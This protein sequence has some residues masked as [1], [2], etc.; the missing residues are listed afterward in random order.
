MATSNHIHLLV[1]DSGNN[2]IPKSMQLVAGRVAQEFNQRKKRKGAFWED[3]YDA[4]AIASD[5]HFARCLTYID[6]NMVRAG[7]V[8]D[9]ADWPESGY[10]ELMQ[11]KQ[12]YHLLDH[13]VLEKMLGVNDRFEMQSTRRGRVEE[14]IRRNSLERD[15]CWSESLAVGDEEFVAGVKEGLEI[16]GWN[17]IV[18]KEGPGFV[19]RESEADYAVLPLEFPL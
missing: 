14:A 5:D 12:R 9:P 2:E 7:V 8:D 1:K 3:R 6:L 18:T 16:R 15:S 17:R 11:T 19:L 10:A 4:T 13:H